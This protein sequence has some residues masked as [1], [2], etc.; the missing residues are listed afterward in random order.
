MKPVNIYALTRVEKSGYLYKL[1][2]QMS[3]R[4]TYLKIKEWEI[5]NVKAVANQLFAILKDIQALNFYYSFQVPKLGKEFDLLSVSENQVINIEL[6]SGDVTEEK[7]KK[8][9]SLNRQYL[10]LLGKSIRSYT[11]VSSTNMLY[12][13]TNSGRLVVSDFGALSKDI[14]KSENIYEDD[15]EKLFKEE[16]YLISPLTDPDKFLRREYFLTF[17]QRD[18]KNKILRKIKSEGYCLQGFTG[19]PGTGKT[20]LLYDIAMELSER[21]KVCVWHLGSFPEELNRLD[22]RLKRIDFFSG[23]DKDFFTT[24]KEYRAILVDEGHRIQIEKLTRLMEQAKEQ[25]I[26][27]IISYDTEEA[28]AKEER[29]LSHIEKMEALPGFIGYHL[30]NR[31]RM[32]SE[33]SS[34]IRLIMKPDWMHKR[35]EYP[36]VSL[37]YSGTEEEKQLLLK[38]YLRK[39][40]TYIEDATC[41]EYEKVVMVMDQNFYYDSNLELRAY[42]DV[43]GRESIGSKESKVRLLFHGLS[44]A[45]TN[46]ALIVNENM[47]VFETIVKSL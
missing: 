1:E 26:P 32:N 41:K 20:L 8:Q 22:E 5:E 29:F 18:I 40:Y 23:K 31:I 4:N 10:G 44:R 11:Y 24:I 9:L 19:L 27:M 30:T 28:I 37:S 46:I 2:K 33:L 47:Q 39:G 16:Y 43:N 35:K 42:C 6:K 13:L 17:Q 45:K 15:L 7:I 12:R 3:R 14:L 36:S 38:D 25:G 34:F 21:E